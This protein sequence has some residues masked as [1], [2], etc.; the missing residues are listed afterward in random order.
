M[1]KKVGRILTLAAVVIA[2]GLVL[3]G[4]VGS[5]GLFTYRHKRSEYETL[6]SHIKQQK[7]ENAALQ[8]EVQ[9][10]RSDPATIERY[11]REDLHMSRQGE[12]IYKIPPARKS[13]V[14]VN[15]D[16]PPAP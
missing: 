10:L 3:Y 7:K 16:P 15:R 1:S 11:A 14:P 8:E 5:D 4:I 9:K 12:L 6:Q 13:T 2:A